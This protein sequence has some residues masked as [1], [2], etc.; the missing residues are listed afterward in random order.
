[1]DDA[2]VLLCNEF[3]VKL[4]ATRPVVLSYHLGD[5]DF[6]SGDPRAREP[7]FIV[8]S[9]KENR[10]LSST[11]G[12]IEPIYSMTSEDTKVTYYTTLYKGSTIA[13]E[14][15]IRF[16]L[17]AEGLK[18]EWRNCIEYDGFQ[19]MSMD[20]KRVVSVLASQEIGRMALPTH[21]G[22]M[23]NPA[24]CSQGERVHRYSWIHDSFCMVATVYSANLAAVLFVD[25][26]DDTMLS[27]VEQE[28]DHRSAGLGIQF[29]HRYPASNP[30]AQFVAHSS[31]SASVKLLTVDIDNAD[32]GW[33]HAAR[34]IRDKVKSRPSPVYEDAFVYKIWIGCPANPS[35]TTFR[36]A[37]EL[38][39]RIHD[40]TDGGRQIA[41]LVGFQHEG[42]DSGYPD[43]FTVNKA[44]GGYEELRFL[45]SEA[46]KLN[47]NVSFHDNYD[48]AYMSSPAWD[49][50]DIG[51]DSEG[52]LRKGG[53][54]NGE[55]AYWISIPV[56][57]KTKAPKRI[58]RTLE[59][60]PICETYH[61]DVLTASVFRVDYRQE[62]P[63]SKDEECEARMWIVQEF[64]KHGID[65]SS[66]GCGMPFLEHI[67]YFWHLPRPTEHVYAGDRRIP[68]APFIAHG[69]VCYGGSH[70]G[71]EGILDGLLFAAFYSDD[72]SL[73]TPENEILD[74]YFLLQV[75][76]NLLREE[77]LED[78]YEQGSR[79]RV[80]YS[81]GSYIEVDFET[82]EFTVSVNG[83]TVAE[84]FVC[85][86]PGT[87]PG[88]YLAYVAREGRAKSWPVPSEWRD[89][90]WLRAI[91]LL[92]TGNG[93]EVELEVINGMVYIDFPVGVPYKV[94]S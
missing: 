88:T 12:S 69:H 87:K 75:P 17:S 54:W 5:T 48:D 85:F 62:D 94:L 92:E 21:G 66:E 59:M 77:F 79:K 81:S 64:R 38:I 90:R 37:L 7:H 63:K 39:R 76:L 3:A 18:I 43:V 19:F 42:H 53:V 72:L 2:I 4:D 47:A 52:E 60:Y 71:D 31:S 25:S 1:M 22:R 49:V 51:V 16:V 84:D 45:M 56:Y 67:N 93:E 24:E 23:I 46:E 36:D 33:V 86:A 50:S 91:P 83:Y 11:D 41:Y 61:I 8:F 26:L 55:Q 44:A 58:R 15:E 20:F 14:L 34:Y 28:E 35:E 57:T 65:V 73:A 74:A 10:S 30:S 13:V 27:S 29:R 78:Y 9:E 82:K 68:F 70:V 6:L 80:A 32:T 40:R 89:C